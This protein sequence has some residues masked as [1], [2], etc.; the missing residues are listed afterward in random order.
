[1]ANRPLLSHED[2]GSGMPSEDWVQFVRRTIVGVDREVPLTIGGS[3]RYVDFDNAATTPAFYHVQRTVVDA[4]EWYSSVHR[5]TGYKSRLM[6]DWFETA[7]RTVA[8]FVGADPETHVAI[9]VRNATEGINLVAHRIFTAD[10]D[11][12]ILTSEMEHHSN[13]LPWRRGGEVVHL[14]VEQDGILL[15]SELERQLRS[16]KKRIRLVTLSGASNVTGVIP[17]IYQLAAIAHSHGAL[18]MV[19]AAQPIPHCRVRMGKAGDPTSLDALVF[20][21]HKV[22]APF[23]CGVVIAWRS[24]LQGGEPMLLGGGMIRSVTLEGAD[25]A[26]FPDSDEGG[27]PNVI[28]AL[29]LAAS[30]QELSK[31]KMEVV[32]RKEAELA[33]YALG[34]LQQIPGLTLYGP[35]TSVERLGVF[36]FNLGD[37]PHALVA[38]ALGFEHGIGVR[39]GCFCAHPLMFHL[40]GLSRDQI[41]AF[42]NRVRGPHRNGLPGAVRASLGLYNTREEVDKLIAALGTIV[43]G[44]VAGN[45]VEDQVTGEFL[46][47]TNLGRFPREVSFPPFLT[48]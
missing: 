21:G 23:G 10:P 33:D 39:N 47:R 34:R 14:R 38:A 26:D 29:A 42:R 9:F 16:E 22:Y 46:P 6:T 35:R 27:T 11:A 37:M 2:D 41:M 44:R 40:F 24:L 31:L 43:A 25:W 12:R 15:P 4:L 8:E 3:C 28:G 48:T 19:D 17:P 5:G 45:Y 32:E 7:R 18:F 36:T 13:L 1:M 30:L 20:S